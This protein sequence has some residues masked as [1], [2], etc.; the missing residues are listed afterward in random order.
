MQVKSLA[1]LSD[2]AASRVSEA[3]DCLAASDLSSLLASGVRVFG[4][5]LLYSSL[6]P[7]SRWQIDCYTCALDAKRNSAS[8]KRAS[9]SEQT[10]KNIYSSP[11]EC[12]C[13]RKEKYHFHAG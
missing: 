11:W 1:Q 2:S 6:S 7:D 5:A 12:V 8:A 3:G 13:E 9:I 10:I 4:S